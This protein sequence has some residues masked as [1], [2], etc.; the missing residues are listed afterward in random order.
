M[1]LFGFFVLDLIKLLWLLY[2]WGSFKFVKGG[3]RI[4]ILILISF[5]IWVIFS[6]Y[7]IKDL[8]KNYCFKVKFR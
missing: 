2:D 3:K 5:I 7:W 6:V 8:I 1:Y 4:K